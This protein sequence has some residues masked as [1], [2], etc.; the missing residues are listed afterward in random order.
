MG[1][2]PRELP[3]FT[4]A[5]FERR[6]ERV[7]ALMTEA[8]LDALLVTSEPNM[9]YL[10]GFTTQFAWNTP[11]RPWYFVLP[12]VGRACAV[13]PEVGLSNWRATSWVADVRTWPSP[14]PE[15]EGLDLLA[16][17]LG[18]V[19]RRFG[20]VGAELGPETRLG[21][22][23]ADLLRVKAMIRPLGLADGSAVLRAARLV[24][25]PAE[26][27]RI[28]RACAAAGRAFDA[29]P[30]LVRPGDTEK[31]VVRTFQAELLRQ[32]VDKTPYTSIGT[33]RGG[34]DSIIQGPTNRRLAKGDILL[35]DTG[36]R[37]D[38]YFCDFDRNV[39]I[40]GPPSRAAARVHDLLW[41]ATQAGIDAAR[42]GATAE[43]VFLAQARVLEDGGITLGNVG[44]FGHGLGKVLTEPP[45]NKPGDRTVLR[46][47]TVLTVEPSAMFG[48]GKI[49]VHEENLVVTEDAPELL[50]P[51]AP[52][53]MPIAP[54]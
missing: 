22:P 30:G 20:R 31:D 36:S 11:T 49:L 27:A 16:K 42:P 44:R 12:R 2:E 7:R 54:W 19:R 23:V 33:G 39:A 15:N 8:R 41:R 4:R 43:D 34:Y 40:G 14:R 45:S 26:I 52:R 6:V 5:E 50:T 1:A 47:G 46:P 37:Y 53:A 9:E 18:A 3:P 25:S 32:G 17:A 51:R 29:L 38:G 13:I 28:R 48:A 24:K 35:I 21:M 10:A